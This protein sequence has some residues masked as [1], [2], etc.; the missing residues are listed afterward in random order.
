MAGEIGSPVKDFVSSFIGELEDGLSDKGY[1]TCSENQAHAKMELNAV[2]TVETGGQGG[3]KILGVGG[4]LKT[5]DSNT[6]SQKVTVFVKKDLE[7][8]E[9]EEKARIEIAKKGSSTQRKLH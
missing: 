4:E 6:N 7:V 5:N 2:A 1:S 8:D 3:A 9:E